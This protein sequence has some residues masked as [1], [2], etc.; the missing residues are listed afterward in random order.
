MWIGH[1]VIQKLLSQI[2]AFLYMI[3]SKHKFGHAR[4]TVFPIQQKPKRLLQVV[5]PHTSRKAL[6]L[7]EFDGGYNDVRFA[8]ADATRA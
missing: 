8:Q 4:A 5:S 6:S 7:E 3:Q 2:I 1:Q